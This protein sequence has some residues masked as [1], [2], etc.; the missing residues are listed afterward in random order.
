MR[1]AGKCACGARATLLQV[2]REG[3]GGAD[4]SLPCAP[5]ET[6]PCPGA[7]PARRPRP[8][9]PHG[10]GRSPRGN[11]VHG[12][13]RWLVSVGDTVTHGTREGGRAPGRCRPSPGFTPTAGACLL[14][15]RDAS[16]PQSCPE[17]DKLCASSQDTVS[18]L[19]R[20]FGQKNIKLFKI[21]LI[22]EISSPKVGLRQDPDV[23]RLSQPGTLW[24][25]EH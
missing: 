8:S 13:C 2:G 25:K 14:L 16:F 7:R 3:R 5:E 17:G 18:L 20:F 19:L 12:R 6:A 15:G 21:L 24:P 23:F 11:S 22:Y 4:S 10:P 1:E 9:R